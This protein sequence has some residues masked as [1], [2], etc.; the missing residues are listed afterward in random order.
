MITTVVSAKLIRAFFWLLQLWS[1]GSVDPTDD[2]G[3]QTGAKVAGM[4]GV[5]VAL[6]VA[7]SGAVWAMSEW[8]AER[9][10][11]T[12]APAKITGPVLA[13]SVEGWPIVDGSTVHLFGVDTIAPDEIGRFVSW[14]KTHGD[15][16]ECAAVPPLGSQASPSPLP[17][18][19]TY[20]CFTRD[21]LDVAEAILP[22]P[23][24]FGTACA[25]DQGHRPSPALH[26]QHNTHAAYH[27]AIRDLTTA[28][29]NQQELVRHRSDAQTPDGGIL[30][31]FRSLF[32]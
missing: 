24:P 25:I 21:H 22:N 17:N 4:V 30:G 7:V 27:G 23:T 5:L 32:R 20:R 16:L 12:F 29:L 3:Q 19:T 9:P 10:P 2:S 1:T 31:F 14:I 15:Y 26:P 11:A 28:E 13:L 8:S 6:L 18:G